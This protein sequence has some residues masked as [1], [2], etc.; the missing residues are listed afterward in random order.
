MVAF[1]NPGDQKI[2]E[3][4]QFVPQEKYRTGFTA[5]TTGVEEEV[6]ETSGIPAT[7]AFTNSGG[8]NYFAGSPNSLIQDYN[9]TT[10]DRYFRNQDTPLVDDLY[11]SKLDKTFMG[12]PSYKQQNFVGPF[13]P[14]GQ[15]MDMDNPAASIEN[16]IASR[17][18]PL[19]QTMAGKIQS[20]LGNVRNKA[21]G[22]MSNIKGFGP[23]SM[24]LNAMDRFDTLSPTDQQFINMNMGY[25]GPTVFGENSSGLSKDPFGINTR[26]AFGNY[27]DY[28]EDYNTDYTEEE[29]AGFSKMRQQKIGF[30]KEKQKELQQIKEAE[31]EQQKQ[32][33]QDFQD[34]NPGY[35]DPEKNINPGSGGGKGYDPGADYSGLD[36]RSEDNRSSDLGF[37]DIRLKENV[38]LIGKS[39]S[40]INIYKFNY[41]DSPTTY[42]GAMAHEVPWA[43]VKNPNGYMMIDYNQIDVEFKKI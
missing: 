19:E 27:A 30:Y 8:N 15:P 41:K 20:T 1:Y 35:G 38:E 4:F 23:V 24:A 17:N 26:S 31:I 5:P 33:A 32:A 42:Q 40:N 18:M 12:F 34:K 10:K 39:P 37:S 22:I 2:Y 6:T 25:T 13:T 16:I 29:L 43:S 21:S 9:T 3:D 7:N 36:K 28:V 11:Q 14:Y